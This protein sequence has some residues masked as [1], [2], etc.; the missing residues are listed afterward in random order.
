MTDASSVL[1]LLGKGDAKFN[2]G[3]HKVNRLHE[4]K[5][6]VN[7][8]KLNPKAF[9]SDYGEFNF[10]L[11]FN[12]LNNFLFEIIAKL[13]VEEKN[14]CLDLKKAIEVCE[15]KFPI[16]NEV[17]NF[18]ENKMCWDEGNWKI[19]KAYYEKYEEKLNHYADIHK[20]DMPE[21]SMSSLF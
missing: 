18:G 7:F 12:S 10:K 21:K 1:E 15:K 6:L 20:F 13:K 16:Q 17:N 3:Y 9:N 11:W 2:A 8:C 5:Q 14:D 4:I 19:F